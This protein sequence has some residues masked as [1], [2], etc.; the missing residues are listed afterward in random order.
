MG[1]TAMTDWIISRVAPFSASPFDE[2]C[3]PPDAMCTAPEPEA[4]VG[5]RLFWALIVGIGLP[6]VLAWALQSSPH[7]EPVTI[8][9]TAIIS[10]TATQLPTKH[11]TKLPKAQSPPLEPLR[12][13]LN[14]YACSRYAEN[15]TK[16]L[17][18]LRFL[19]R[20]EEIKQIVD[21]FSD[22]YF[23]PPLPLKPFFGFEFE[24]LSPNRHLAIVGVYLLAPINQ[25][26]QALA[27]KRAA[28]AD[29]QLGKIGSGLA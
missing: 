26:S 16:C 25:P 7:P 21:P 18:I 29:R 4:A 15:G 9:R 3:N 13:A 17:V 8:I 20:L 11:A 5:M 19:H 14:D 10:E 22:L 24:P 28:I 1:W 23:L 6:I 2:Y 27:W 12:G